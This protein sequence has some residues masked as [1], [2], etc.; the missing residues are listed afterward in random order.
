MINSMIRSKR[1]R[2]NILIL[3]NSLKY[4]N[5][6]EKKL[7][8][9]AWIVSGSSVSISQFFSSCH[10]LAQNWILKEHCAP[11]QKY[12]SGD[13]GDALISTT[14]LIYNSNVYLDPGCHCIAFRSLWGN[15]SVTE[16]GVKTTTGGAKNGLVKFTFWNK[17]DMV[18]KS[19]FFMGELAV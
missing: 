2:P 3:R 11:M 15:I 12:P 17:T 13:L 1:K 4:E 5:L 7:L 9:L 18:C 8:T 6:L 14:D 19:H 10:L 16:F